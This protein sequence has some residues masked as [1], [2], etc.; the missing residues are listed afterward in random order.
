[1]GTDPTPA[2]TMR[3][4]HIS[5]TDLATLVDLLPP[6]LEIGMDKWTNLQRVRYRRVQQILT[7]VQWNY[8][9]HTNIQ[10]IDADRQEEHDGN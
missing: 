7:N 4:L 6:L 9:P 10:H 3:M 1:M 5:S 8:G 2:D